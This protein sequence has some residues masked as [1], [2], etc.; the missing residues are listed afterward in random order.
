MS[1]ESTSGILF[2]VLAALVGMALGFVTIW[3]Q[4]RGQNRAAKLDMEATKLDLEKRVREH[5][6]LKLE[7]IEMQ[8]NH[9]K[10]DIARL[11]KKIT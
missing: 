3:S 4:I 8:I 2:Y 1:S 11:S 10:E 6:D 9:I 5:L 7:N